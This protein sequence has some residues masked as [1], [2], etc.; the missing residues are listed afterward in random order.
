[1]LTCQANEEG[2]ESQSKIAL[3]QSKQQIA[4]LQKGVSLSPF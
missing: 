4:A 2:E 3:D 1:M